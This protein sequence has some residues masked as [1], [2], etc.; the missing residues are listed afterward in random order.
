[1]VFRVP[2]IRTFRLPFKV[3]KPSNP[4]SSTLFL[5]AGFA[6]LILL[7]TILLT[8]PVSSSSGQFTSPIT[9]LFTATSAVCV[10]GL[11]VVD[12]GTY[13][14]TFGQAVLL[15]LFQIGGLG[16]ITGATIL[17]MA[18]AGRFGLRE[19]LVITESMGL[20][21]LGGLLGVVSKVAVF[22]LV[23]EAA[24]AA[25]FYFHW[26]ATNDGT[27][28]LWVSVFHSVSAFNNCGMDI[29]G[30]FKSLSDLQGD[31]LFLMITAI[32]VILGST[33]Y[34]VIADVLGKHSFSKLLL[35]SKMV[36]IIT[37]VLL[38]AGT[39]FIF[40]MEYS[41]QVTLGPLSIPSKITVAFFQAVVPRTA[42]FSAIDIS[43][44]KSITL[45]FVMGLMFIGGAAGSTAGG[46]KIN[47]I[48][49]LLLTVFSTLKG[50]SNIE[51]FG[52]QLTVSTVYR[53]VTLFLA[54]LGIAGLVI[55]LLSITEVF[56]IEQILFE[57]FSALS[58]VGLTAGVTPEL[59]LAGRFII[60]SAMFIGRLG[61]LVLMA[62]MGRR[63][64]MADLDYPH[65]TIRLG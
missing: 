1:L 19:R 42:G 5:L 58:T 29:F 8:F 21:R 63:R 18:F 43:G 62:T 12:T 35:D 31:T 3:P 34:V 17:L 64:S 23:L 22:S 41:N 65:E 46:I 51:A 52:R 26:L 27:V 9:A 16:F 13:W 53:A 10:T 54:Y 30:G 49:V 33:S 4:F 28:S 50:K 39:L 36:L 57:T 44:L 55:L 59:S 38:A 45:F 14:S 15:I 61:P 40:G 6:G 20:D 25:I 48:G 32:L 37:L 7:G 60:I 47:T 2:G 56:T 24:G 11:V